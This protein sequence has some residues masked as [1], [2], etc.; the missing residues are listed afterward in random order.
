MARLAP[1]GP[2]SRFAAVARAAADRYVR[3]PTWPATA[4][5]RAVLRDTASA[6]RVELA[7]RDVELAV[8]HRCQS[9]REGRPGAS[10]RGA[11][12][13]STNTLRQ[14]LRLSAQGRACPVALQPCRSTNASTATTCGCRSRPP[15][16]SRCSGLAFDYSVLDDV[17]PSHRGL[18]T[19]T[20]GAIAQT[21]VLGGSRR[22]VFA[23]HRPSRWRAFVEYLQAGVWHIWSGIDHLL[24][25]LSL[26]LPA[27]LLRRPD[28]GRR[29]RRRARRCSTS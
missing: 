1:D 18:L 11:R 20:A 5:W 19:L 26:L 21:A 29:C 3:R 6:V 14:H 16:R 15:A 7:V 24:F 4:S 9:G 8:G 27:V 2:M 13:R 23:S 25:L 28:A 17:D 12:A 10:A 22:R